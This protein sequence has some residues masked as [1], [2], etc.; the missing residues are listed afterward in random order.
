MHRLIAALLAALLALPA[1]AQLDLSLPAIGDPAADTLTRGQEERL[2]REM[3]TE[4]RRR[5]PLLDDAEVNGYLRD[6]GARLA[7][8]APDPGFGFHFFVV[9]DTRINAFAMPGGYIGVHTGLILNARTESQ[10]G[11]VIAHEIAHVTQRHLARRLQASQGLS[12]R[13][14]AL[15]LAGILLGTQNPQA[16]SAATVG[17]LASQVQSELSYSRDH[18]READRIG[19]Q[20]LA[21]SGLEPSGMAEFFDIL[22]RAGRYRDEPPP[23]LS[24]HPLTEARVAEGRAGAERYSG[25]RVFESPDFQFT[26]ARVLV[27]SAGSPGEAAGQ[28]RSRLGEGEAGAPAWATRYGLALALSADGRHAEAQSLL[29]ELLAERGEYAALM[30]A[31]AVNHGRAGRT[32]RA[33]EVIAEAA[34]L[35]PDDYAVR[36]RRIELLLEAGRN[37][38]AARRASEASHRHPDDPALQRLRARAADASGDLAEAA[39]AMGQ[40][41]A[42]LGDFA[43]ALNQ[44]RK[45]LE[46]GR[47][48]EYQRSRASALQERWRQALE[49]ARQDS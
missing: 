13:T 11:G 30:I 1:A 14:A 21:S 2:G 15:V 34:S 9:E 35:F 23:F 36:F 31:L 8:R 4:V 18:E 41:Y 44:A 16:G 38:E 45:V 37:A 29:E 28:L 49:A 6:L 43:S 42:L 19:L 17:A 12:L 26:R 48:D 33:V 10:L 3:M 24:T 32:E 47:A 27:L 20:I 46:Q 25:G 39:L 5:L 40:Y 7:A 22:L